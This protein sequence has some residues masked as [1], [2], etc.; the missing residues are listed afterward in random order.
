MPLV[1]HVPLPD[2][3]RVHPDFRHL[4]LTTAL[5]FTSHS[6]HRSRGARSRMRSS[7]LS[8]SPCVRAAAGIILSCARRHTDLD[9]I[10]G[11]RSET[12]AAYSGTMQ[13]LRSHYVPAKRTSSDAPGQATRTATHRT[14][15]FDTQIAEGDGAT[16]CQAEPDCRVANQ[17]RPVSA[18]RGALARS[19]P[20]S[21]C[22]AARKPGA[23]E[24]SRRHL[25][26]RRW[27]W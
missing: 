12:R 13:G 24:G 16:G 14:P 25:P 4:T 26:P 10:A 21:P 3:D 20:G 6:R 1:Q 22:V 19:R 15:F 8:R 27:R 5:P 2:R 17:G 11:F 9:E 18:T 23:L 7:G